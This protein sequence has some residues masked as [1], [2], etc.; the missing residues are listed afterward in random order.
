MHTLL[1]D[2]TEWDLVLDVAG[3]IAVATE[4]YSIAQDVSS[5]ARL[6]LGELWFDTTQG[7]P[8]WQEILGHFPTPSVVKAA[9]VK[10]AKKVPGV[11]DAVCYLSGLEG[12]RLSGQI[13]VTLTSGGTVVVGF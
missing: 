7:V 10:E 3:N 2:R 1:L 13:Q 11:A 8:Y 6:F 4:P 9:I 12:R 5:A